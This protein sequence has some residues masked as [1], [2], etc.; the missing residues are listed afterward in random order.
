MI[1]WEI[2]PIA[3]FSHK[4]EVLMSHTLSYWWKAEHLQVLPVLKRDATHSWCNL[5]HHTAGGVSS[6][7]PL[8]TD[9]FEERI[10]PAPNLP[11]LCRV[12][13]LL[14][15]TQHFRCVRL[16]PDTNH[17]RCP[18]VCS[19][20]RLQLS[21]KRF[22]EFTETCQW[23]SQMHNFMVLTTQQHEPSKRI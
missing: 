11:F 6:S 16:I 22:K 23:L 19:S 8:S 4:I 10:H 21:L 3:G 7:W 18:L 1:I 17:C 9:A 12:N 20:S 15:H 13:K 5:L 14:V 2:T